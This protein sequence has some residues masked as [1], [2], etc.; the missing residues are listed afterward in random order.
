MK[1]ADTMVLPRLAFA[2]V[3][4]EDPWGEGRPAPTPAR[5]AA[6]DA[7]WR[8]GAWLVPALLM[9]VLSVIGAGAPGL[10]TEELATW[11]RATSSWR[12]NWS[13]LRTGEA[14]ELPYHLLMRAWA[15][16]FGTS[17]LALRVPSMLAMT[18]AAALVGALAARVFAP[19]TGLLAGVV[20]ALLP[21]SARYAQEAQP[22]A[23]TL[24]AAVL[25][26]WCLLPAI[27]RPWRWRLARYA[28]AVALL[29]LCHVTGLLLLAGH[30]WVVLAFRRERA[31]RWLAAASA[32]A[33]PAA[34]LLW[35]AAPHGVHLTR[36]APDLRALAATPR[37]LFGVAALGGV[38]LALALFSLPLRYAP[39]ICTAW[40]VVPPLVLLLIAQAT[41]IWA[42]EYL[43]LTL[44]AWAVLGAIALARVRVGWSVGVLV[45]IALAGAPAQAALRQPDGHGQASRELVQ[46][47][48]RRLQPG[49]GVVYGAADGPAGRNLVAHYLPADRR[50]RDVLAA[51][52]RRPGERQPAAGCA[53]AA[54]C[55]SGTQRLWVIRPGERADP[56]HG[57]G[58]AQEGP[59]RT[60]YRVAQVWRP[61]GLTLALLVAGRTDL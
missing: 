37:E 59:L 52:P 13:M 3:R 49:D 32:G 51:G 56:L 38:L 2:E 10:R 46:I 21:G 44:P 35:L 47:L 14:I 5:P 39:A 27:D 42:P 23:L 57:I 17:D 22:Y 36:H 31:L 34:T 50:P 40:A 55:L 41:P 43:L 29:G 7:R 24:L 20:F 26:T 58:G 45:A 6:Q 16:V 28:G 25:A 48:E 12:D 15:E 30:G 33:L 53:G 9:G 60:G 61:K 4:A 19:G 1:D 54:G 8:R 11:A 18:V